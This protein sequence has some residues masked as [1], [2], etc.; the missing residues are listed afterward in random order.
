MS[1]YLRLEPCGLG[2]PYVESFGSYLHRLASAHTISLYQLI[3]HVRHWWN[4]ELSNKSRLPQHCEGVRFSGYSLDNQRL[5]AALEVGTGIASLA[6]CT[7]LPLRDVCAGNGIGALKKT[8][9]WCPACYDEAER[10]HEVIY[11]RLL[12]QIQG[13]RRCGVHGVR[14]L[15]E[16]PTCRSPQRNQAAKTTLHVC[17]R[18]G[19]SLIGKP[20]SWTL[21]RLGDVFEYQMGPVLEFTS[22]NPTTIFS[23]DAVHLFCER[24]AARFDRSELIRYVGDAF[25]KRYYVKRFQ[26]T[27]IVPIAA[28]FGVPLISILEDP[29]SVSVQLSLDVG[30]GLEPIVRMQR[31]YAIEMH[32]Y[33]SKAIADA[34][35]EG[36]PYKTINDICGLFDVSVSFAQGA[37][38]DQVRRLMELRRKYRL[39]ERRATVLR[40]Y[41]CMQSLPNCSSSW[42]VKERHKWVATRA[43]APLNVV[44]KTM[45]PEASAHLGLIGVPQARCW[46]NARKSSGASEK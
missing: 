26:L 37:C 30:I 36:P 3:A 33:L 9:A 13:V 19:T 40:I 10:G 7:L 14:L 24:M 4:V 28:F 32:H 17:E 25:H 15:R 42:T 21:D 45:M 8:R 12:W 22:A 44:R 23:Y 16:C 27:S 35:E 1:H 39:S 11:D 6:G 41:R 18:C 31:R 38:P 46:R 2:T 29:E 43:R 34:L 5:A 20:N